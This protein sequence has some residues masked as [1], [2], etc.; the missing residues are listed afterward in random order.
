MYFFVILNKIYLYYN[1]LYNIS[2][3]Y[4]LA[5]FYIEFETPNSV[6]TSHQ[7][8]ERIFGLYIYI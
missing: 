8:I 7:L 3:I 2:V 1:S 4:I 5:R 6:L